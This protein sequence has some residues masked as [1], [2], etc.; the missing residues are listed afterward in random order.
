MPLPVGVTGPVAP[1]VARRDGQDDQGS[2]HPQRDK[3]VLT[4]HGHAIIP[5]I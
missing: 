5:A 4:A 3:L 2:E 1:R